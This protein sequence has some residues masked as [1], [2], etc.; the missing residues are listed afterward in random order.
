[1]T[2]KLGNFRAA[3]FTTT[4]AVDEGVVVDLEADE[5]GELVEEEMA[6]DDSPLDALRHTEVSYSP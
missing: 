2:A 3:L 4:V 6:V 1:M 5:E